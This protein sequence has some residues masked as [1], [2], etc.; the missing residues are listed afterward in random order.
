ML[1]SEI[2]TPHR[3]I[4]YQKINC[5]RHVFQ[6]FILPKGLVLKFKV[7]TKAIQ[8][9]SRKWKFSLK[10]DLIVEFCIYYIGRREIAF[11]F[12]VEKRQEA[13]G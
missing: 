6:G 10:I 11:F 13:A 2:K 8:L 7:S 5:N 9:N 3:L 12:F 4:Y 1:F